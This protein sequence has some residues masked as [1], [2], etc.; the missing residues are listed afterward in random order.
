MEKVVAGNRGVARRRALTAHTVGWAKAPLRRAHHTAPEVMGT[1]PDAFASSRFAHPTASLPHDARDKPRLAPRRLDVLFQIAVRVAADIAGSCIGPG[2]A[3]VVG[4]AR[5]L[6]GLVAFSAFHVEI[7]IVAAET[8]DRG[9]DRTAVLLDHAGAAHAGDA[10]IVLGARRHVALEPAHR[11]AGGIGRII[12]APGAA[13][14]VALAY[15]RAIRRIAGLHR[16]TRIIAAGPVEIGLRLRIARVCD[17]RAD[18]Q[19]QQTRLEQ[20]GPPHT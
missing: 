2:A 19:R 1:S 17:V 15:Q 14:A 7:A 3:F 6:A 18:N 13:A 10:A 20:A 8:V 16:R 5:R 11:A 12:E 9:F 4:G